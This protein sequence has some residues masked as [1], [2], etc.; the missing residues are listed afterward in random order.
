M[1]DVFYL[2][3]LK[4]KPN[5]N[6]LCPRLGPLKRPRNNDQSGKNKHPYHPDC[7]LEISFPIQRHKDS[8]VQNAQNEPE[9]PCYIPY[10]KKAI[11]DH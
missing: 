4:P 3:K 7:S 2:K 6:P 5:Q 8:S 10:T 1:Q 11:K 9:I